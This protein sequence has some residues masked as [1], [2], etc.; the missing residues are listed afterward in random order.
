MPDLFIEATAR[1]TDYLV[2]TGGSSGQADYR[3]RRQGL[4]GGRPDPGRTGRPGCWR[5]GRPRWVGLVISL[6][7]SI[8]K[9]SPIRSTGEKPNEQ[10]MGL[11]EVDP[12]HTE[13]TSG[14]RRNAARC[15]WPGSTSVCRCSVPG[16]VNPCG[17]SRSFWNRR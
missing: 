7:H 1:Q 11:Q 6:I 12:S 13:P 9:S 2:G 4:G 17:S 3:P 16:A 8:A 14:I 15:C 5:S 10:K